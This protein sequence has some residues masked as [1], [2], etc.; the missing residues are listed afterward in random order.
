MERSYRVIVKNSAGYLSVYEDSAESPLQILKRFKPKH[1]FTIEE[2]HPRLSTLY[3]TMFAVKGDRVYCASRDII[4][5]GEIEKRW[6]KTRIED[7]V[8]KV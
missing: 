3:T 4:H 5:S 7:V 6:P 8:V 2:Q 1:L